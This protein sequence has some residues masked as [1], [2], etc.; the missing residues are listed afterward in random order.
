MTITRQDIVDA[1]RAYNGTPWK[2]QGRLKGVGVDCAG[3]LICA[4]NDSGWSKQELGNDFH[5]SNYGRVPDGNAMVELLDT[6]LVRVSTSE[7]REGDVLLM[8]FG[9]N[10]QHIAVVTQIE[11]QPYIIHAYLQVRRVTEH[12]LDEGWLAKVKGVYRFGGID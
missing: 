1:A 11:P 2:H 9:S 7:M 5:Y 10:P 12:R 6:H 3:V 4:A 8:A